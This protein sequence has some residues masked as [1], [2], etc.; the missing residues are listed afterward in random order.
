QITTG[1]FNVGIGS[2]VFQG[3]TGSISQNVGIGR[4]ALEACTGNNNTAIG[5]GAGASIT[6]GGQNTIISYFGNGCSFTTGDNNICIGGHSSVSAP[7]ITTGSNNVV[8]G[9]VSG[10]STSLA[11]NIILADGAGNI[12]AQYSNNFVWT[13]PTCTVSQ[14]PAAGT[15]GRRG[16]VT[17]ATAT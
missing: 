4:K 1:S 14:L 5:F 17:D 6:S 11:N 2:S 15:A 10:L 7:G 16:F 8:I 12:R 9:Q 13:Y 3:A